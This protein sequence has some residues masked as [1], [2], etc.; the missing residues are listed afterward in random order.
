MT[1]IE[2]AAIV[3]EPSEKGRFAQ[4]YTECQQGTAFCA[5]LQ[6]CSWLSSDK[7]VFSTPLPTDKNLFSRPSPPTCQF[8]PSDSGLTSLSSKLASISP[9]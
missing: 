4:A 9:V 8:T 1:R 7:A 2:N 5:N 6:S 3:R